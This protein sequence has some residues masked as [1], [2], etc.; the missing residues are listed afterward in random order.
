MFGKSAFLPADEPRADLFHGAA[1]PSAPPGSHQAAAESRHG[2][3]DIRRAVA[4]DLAHALHEESIR[5]V[6]SSP[7]SNRLSAMAASASPHRRARARLPPEGAACGITKR[8]FAPFGKVLAAVHDARGVLVTENG[9]GDFPVRHKGGTPPGTFRSATPCCAAAARYPATRDGFVPLVRRHPARC[10][11]GRT[12]QARHTTARNRHNPS[13]A[14][15]ML[16]P[17]IS[18]GRRNFLFPAVRGS[19]SPFRCSVPYRVPL[20]V[21]DEQLGHFALSPLSI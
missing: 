7:F 2:K 20:G 13:R 21:A 18:E 5:E 10:S 11:G 4:L 9:G 12:V 17:C 3:F 6:I 14:Q 1:R 16:I 8:R 15:S 19:I